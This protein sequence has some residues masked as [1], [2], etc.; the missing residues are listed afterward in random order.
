[1]NDVAPAVERLQ[2]RIG[3]LTEAVACL[4]PMLLEAEASQD[5]RVQQ[6]VPFAGL[7]WLYASAMRDV[8]QSEWIEGQRLWNAPAL[9]AIARPLLEI[10]PSI[11]LFQH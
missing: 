11:L 7:F 4:E 5:E 1:M 3:T 10:I 2:S 8:L 9:A 6:A